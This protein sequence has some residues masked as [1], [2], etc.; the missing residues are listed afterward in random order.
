[1]DTRTESTTRPLAV[2][3][4]DDPATVARQGV[5]A[6]LAEESRVWSTW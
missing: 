2:V 3:T 5:D 4:G 6:L 1:M